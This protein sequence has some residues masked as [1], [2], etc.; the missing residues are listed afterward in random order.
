[1]VYDGLTVSDLCFYVDQNAAA[2][3]GWFAYQEVLA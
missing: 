3:I 1:M 2:R